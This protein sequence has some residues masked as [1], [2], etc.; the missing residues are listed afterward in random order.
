MRAMLCTSGSS[1]NLCSPC[2]P[3]LMMSFRLARARRSTTSGIRCWLHAALPMLARAYKATLQTS[4]RGGWH[5][6]LSQDLKLSLVAFVLKAL[7][8]VGALS[9]CSLLRRGFLQLLCMNQKTVN[10]FEG[11]LCIGREHTLSPDRV[12]AL[13]CDSVIGKAE[14]PPKERRLQRQ[15]SLGSSRRADAQPTPC[16][17]LML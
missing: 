2:A 7:G 10:L 1:Q 4:N 16:R 14:T 12:V 13:W 15:S 11:F 5:D 9:V 17:R 8:G 6:R 3:C